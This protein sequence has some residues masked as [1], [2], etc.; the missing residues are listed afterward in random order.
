[1]CT[2]LAELGFQNPTIIRR[3]V[4]LLVPFGPKMTSSFLL[5]TR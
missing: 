2:S 1:M 5:S 4:D 3:L